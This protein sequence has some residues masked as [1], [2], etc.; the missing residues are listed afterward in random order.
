VL[1]ERSAPCYGDERTSG[2]PGRGPLVPDGRRA[3][4]GLGGVGPE[5]RWPTVLLGTGRRLRKASPKPSF[6]RTSCRSPYETVPLNIL[7][8]SRYSVLRFRTPAMSSPFEQGQLPF[9]VRGRLAAHPSAEIPTA[10][11]GQSPR[12]G[13]ACPPTCANDGR[14]RGREDPR[15]VVRGV[16]SPA[17]RRARGA[18]RRSEH[19]AAGAVVAAGKRPISQAHGALTRVLLPALAARSVQRRRGLAA[20]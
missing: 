13:P 20:C 7:N 5:Q 8:R 12:R 17:S 11:V 9:C 4:R 14:T 10:A 18:R 3:H 15:D 6:L 19:R 16:L 2:R 1:V